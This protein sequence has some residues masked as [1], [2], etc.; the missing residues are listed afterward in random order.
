MSGIATILPESFKAYDTVPYSTL[1]QL[2]VSKAG[3]RFRYAKVG[4]SALVL[5]NLLQEPAEDT[6]FV[7]MAVPAAVAIGSQFITVT[8]GTTTVAANDHAM[9][10]LTIS[11]G[12]GIGQTFEIVGN[13]A[14]G[15]GAAITYQISGSLS[16]ALDTSSKVS[17]RQNPYNGV[18]QSPV[19]T[20]TGGPVGFAISVAPAA[21]YCWVQS[22]GDTAVLF[23]TGTN[24]ASDAEG[25]APSVAVA[26]S[27][28]ATPSAAGANCIG[29][30][31]QVASVDSTVSIAHITID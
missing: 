16:V 21:N 23:D 18:I 3:N 20:Q 1:G 27:V 13:T 12:T 15:S 14:G 30:G 22:G 5:A 11:T 6:Q 31:R 7:S 19:T 2:A 24:T 25:I 28:K 10:R 9:G 4:A 26:G 17:V 29:F 8:N